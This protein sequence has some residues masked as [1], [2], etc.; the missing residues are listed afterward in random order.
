MIALTP[1][2]RAAIPDDVVD[3]CRRLHEQGERG[4]IVGG[5]IRDVLLGRPISDWD[6]ATSAT[7]ERVAVLAALNL[8]HELVTVVVMGLI[9]GLFGFPG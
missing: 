5:C 3:L 1:S 7:P 4:W 6:V 9:I 8:A 2:Q